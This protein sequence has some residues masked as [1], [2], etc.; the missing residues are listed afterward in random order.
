MPQL[1]VRNIEENVVRNLRLRAAQ[2]GVSV[3][4]EHRRILR[5][6][7]LSHAQSGK[8]FADYLLAIPVAADD[9]PPDLFARHRD[10]PKDVE[11]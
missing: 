3:E 7:L 11:L 6:A 8:T 2:N 10:L 4:E 9:E 5:Q 1:I